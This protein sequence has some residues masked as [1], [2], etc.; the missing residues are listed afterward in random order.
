MLNRKLFFV[1]LK[2]IMRDLSEKKNKKKLAGDP[3]AYTE[4]RQFLTAK[5][6]PRDLSS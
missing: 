3:G 6:P 4:T 2:N 1:V 5:R